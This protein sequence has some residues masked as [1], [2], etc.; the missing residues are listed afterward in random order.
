MR[1]ALM[2]TELLIAMGMTCVWLVS[3]AAYA[4]GE[5]T[6]DYSSDAHSIADLPAEAA[7]ESDPADPQVLPDEEPFP[8]DFGLL[9]Q[10]L[11][12]T[13]ALGFFTKLA[14]KN[15]VDDLL[16]A[17]GD[18]HRGRIADKLDGLQERYDLLILKVISLLQDSDPG[19]SEAIA[20]SRDALWNLLADPVKFAAR[21]SQGVDP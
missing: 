9:E 13:D 7:D 14:L 4:N 6:V 10:R 15:D 1:S 16:H 21:E 12:D 18:Y 19:L 5:G 3:G 17:V 20:T 2:Q 11:R 8:L